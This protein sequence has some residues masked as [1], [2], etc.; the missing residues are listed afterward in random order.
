M[1]TVFF[2]DTQN[3]M[4]QK[5]PRGELK[6]KMEIYELGIYSSVEEYLPSK[7]ESL[8]SS[9][10]TYPPNQNGYLSQQEPEQEYLEAPIPDL[11]GYC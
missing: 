8:D 3:E 6:F 2:K 1:C 9:S 7:Q 11:N 5:A 10:T 4:K